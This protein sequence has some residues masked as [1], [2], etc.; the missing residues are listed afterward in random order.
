MVTPAMN[1]SKIPYLSALIALSYLF[2]PAF[3]ATKD[4]IDCMKDEG[5]SMMKAQTFSATPTPADGI[6]PSEFTMAWIMRNDKPTSR[7]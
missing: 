1:E 2:A 3:W 7:S 6:S 5:T 4:D